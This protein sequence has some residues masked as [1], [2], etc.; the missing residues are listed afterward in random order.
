MSDVNRPFYCVWCGNTLPDQESFDK[1]YQ[2]E[3][4]DEQELS[5]EEVFELIHNPKHY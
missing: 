5:E 1:H 4:E 2:A 3:L